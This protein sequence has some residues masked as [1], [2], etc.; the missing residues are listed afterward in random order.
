MRY[1]IAALLMV[2]IVGSGCENRS[3][4][5]DRAALM[6][7]GKSLNEIEAEHGKP[8]TSVA[9][10]YGPVTQQFADQHPDVTT[11]I[12]ETDGGKIYSTIDNKTGKCISSNFLR[13]GSKW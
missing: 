8:T 12:F 4:T 6:L 9:E 3:E 10:H 11:Y 1:V 13:D 2:L 7:T 5:S